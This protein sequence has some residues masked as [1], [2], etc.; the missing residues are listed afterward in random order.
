MKF[1]VKATIVTLQI[2]ACHL[3]SFSVC[4]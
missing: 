2:T 1:A 3:F 4:M